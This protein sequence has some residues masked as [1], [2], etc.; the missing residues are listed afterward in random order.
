[1]KIS[2]INYYYVNWLHLSKIST[3]PCLKYYMP[4]ELLQPLLFLDNDCILP[5]EQRKGNTFIKN[6]F[7]T[8][9]DG[10]LFV[11]FPQVIFCVWVEDQHQILCGILFGTR[12]ASTIDEKWWHLAQ[13]MRWKY[14]ASSLPTLLWIL[15]SFLFCLLLSCIV[16]KIWFWVK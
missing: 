1:M 3:K 13:R 10:F 9:I 15:R 5:K 11:Y 4:L 12:T 2:L 16:G 7:V 8:Q 14:T 6:T